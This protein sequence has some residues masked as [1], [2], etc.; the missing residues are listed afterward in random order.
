MAIKVLDRDTINQIAAGEVIERPASVVKELMENAIDAGASAITVEIKDGGT[1]FIRVTDNG[2]GIAKEEIPVAFLRH[3]TSKISDAADLVTV[4]SLG[5]R[6][7]ALSSIAAVSK[8]EMITK[9]SE[10]LT[11]SRYRIEGG[12]EKG[13]EEVGAPDGTTIVARDLFYNTPA[14]KKFLKSAQTEA[15]HV[16]D[17]VEKIALSRPDISVR[18][19]ING[20]NKLH[21]SGNNNLKDLIYTVYGREISSSLIPVDAVSDMMHLY[22]FIAAPAI[23]R[24]NRNFENYFINGRYIKSNIIA[25][26]I[27]DGFKTYLMQHKYPFTMLYL[28]VEPEM[29]DVNVHPSKMELR[30]RDAESVYDLICHATANALSERELIPASTIGDGREEAKAE[31]EEKAAALKSE[32]HNRPEPFEKKRIGVVNANAAR[33]EFKSYG[34]GMAETAFTGSGTSVLSDNIRSSV[35]PDAHP[36]EQDGSEKESGTS[37]GIPSGNDAKYASRDTAAEKEHVEEFPGEP[38]QLEM[39]DDRL[40][41]KAAKKKHRL[42]GQVFDTYWLIE[43]GDELYIMDQHAAHEKVL[44]E[45]NFAALKDREYTSQIV[46]PPIILS[47][48]RDEEQVLNDHMDVF[49]SIGY[50]IEPFGGC[51]YAVR[52]VPANL[53]SI[54]KK[55]LLLELLDDLT[56]ELDADNLS[57]ETI[58]NKVATMSCK[59]A[60]KGNNRLSFEEADELINELLELDNPYTCPHGRPTIISISKREMEKK[61][62]RIV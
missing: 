16:S 42:I 61:F 29:V 53:F 54:A 59:A 33:E 20:Q 18:L 31:R 60:V 41:S 14:R 24:G 51:D 11:G 21:T 27:E 9:I 45:K 40:L 58:Y 38:E 5:F 37:N 49:N 7:E 25:K 39:F 35:L 17:L 19:I 13:L 30:F 46:D 43:Y 2:S 8:V 44:F 47:L 57:S 50:E 62:K 1:S 56:E 28:D 10:S 36:L 55:E 48:T 34:S 32:D 3:S 6:G 4:A 15:S 23:A 52:A 12:E 26:A 22:G